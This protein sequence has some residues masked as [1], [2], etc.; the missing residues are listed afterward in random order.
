MGI[1]VSPLPNESR[2]SIPRL[3]CGD[4]VARWV[5][6]CLQPHGDSRNMAQPSWTGSTRLSSPKSDREPAE[7]ISPESGSRNED[8]QCRGHPGAWH[9]E[10][11]SWLRLVESDRGEQ[12]GETL[13][14][15]RK[16]GSTGQFQIPAGF[17]W[18]ECEVKRRNVRRSNWNVT[19]GHPPEEDGLDSIAKEPE[20]ATAERGA[21]FRRTDP[22]IITTRWAVWFGEDERAR[23]AISYWL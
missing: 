18:Q 3:R 16:C 23:G 13:W 20:A 15:G 14:R 7:R 22:S 1:L 2:A 21:E 19:V 10:C 12:E 17:I 4:L 9:T 5:R 8:D 11:V 6:S